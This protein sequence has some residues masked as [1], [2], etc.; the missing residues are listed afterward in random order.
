MIAVESFRRFRG[1]DFLVLIGFSLVYVLLSFIFNFYLSS[2]LEYI[3][4]LGLLI[5]F[6]SFIVHLVR[7]AG[8]AL[9]FFL[10]CSA[11]GYWLNDFGVIGLNKIILFLIAGFVFEL[12]YLLFKLE[13]HNVQMDI[14]IGSSLSALSI[15]V[16][17]SLILSMDIALNMLYS[18][19]NLVLLSFFVGVAAS[20]CSFLF[21]Y[22]VKT[23]KFVLK[24]EYE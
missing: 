16:V 5:F 11:F 17:F 24:F 13:F 18:F 21:W 19:F 9:L 2:V 7:K 20:V 22:K 15:P 8:S 1:I 12:M 6:M 14:I 10:F 3:L 4:S 23:S